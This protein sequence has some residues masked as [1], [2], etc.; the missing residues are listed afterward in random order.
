MKPSLVNDTIAQAEVNQRLVE[1]SVEK[2]ELEVRAVEENR[3]PTA[4]EARK[5]KKLDGEAAD[6]RDQLD[7]A[8]GMESELAKVPRATD[9]ETLGSRVRV[10]FEPSTVYRPDLPNS[11]F[12][13]LVNRGQS[14][15]AEARI[16][17]HQ[18]EINVEQ[19]AITTSSG[20]PGL[21]PPQY[22][23]DQIATFARAGRVLANRCQNLPL[24]DV[25]MTF[26]IPRVTTGSTTA[27]QGSE[28]GAVQDSSPVTDYLALAV[29]TV[30]GKIDLSR[31]LFDRSN[32][33]V[34][35]VL[36]QDLAADYAKQLDTQLIS[37]A[38]NGVTVLSGTNA[39]TFTTGSPTVA[40]LYPKVADAIQQVAVNRF[41]P[42][43]GIV[44]HPRRWAWITAAVDTQNRPL[45]VPEGNSSN[46]VALFTTP[47][48]EGA[49]GSMQ[50]LPVF[51]DANIPITLGAGTNQD[52][53]IVARFDDDL[54]FEDSTPTV[55]VY[56]GVL[57]A[58]LQ[59]RILCYGYFAFTFARYAKANSIISG[60]GLT[61]PVF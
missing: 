35:T 50:G 5:A 56:D 18:T 49:V 42:A 19:R 29:N 4:S 16:R 46:A 1:I 22:L 36:A 14:F 13:D 34:D 11:F 12:A 32:P 44:M 20:G 38:T 26:N 57:S 15:E 9:T 37:Q 61:S 17:R 54:L 60:T 21:V 45:V 39:I 43:D 58:N 33:S 30:A 40:L 8:A 10:T 25:G 59:V 6:L 31:Q 52:V 7:R 2:A 28:A 48:A 27:V 53:I 47:T 3:Q 51:L 24:P 55:A 23:L 41:A